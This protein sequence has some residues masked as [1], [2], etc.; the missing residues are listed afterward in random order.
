MPERHAHAQPFT[1][2]GAAMG[3]CH[4]GGR[5]GLVDEH[6]AVRIEIGLR[7]EPSQTPH[8]DVRPV[9]LDGV[10][11]LFLRVSPWR[12]KKRWTV[13]MPTGVPRSAN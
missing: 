3:A 9:L 2:R 4:G 6:Q 10:P 8:Q 12:L 7:L 5:P 1:P 11:G 13:P